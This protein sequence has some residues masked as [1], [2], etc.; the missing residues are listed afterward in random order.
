[1]NI[2]EIRKITGL[3]QGKFAKRFGIPVRTLQQWEQG[4]SSPPEYVIRM[5]AY[6]IELESMVDRSGVD[7]GS[8]ADI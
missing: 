6:I 4:R 1:M 5:I 2:A 8:D 7:E 3:S